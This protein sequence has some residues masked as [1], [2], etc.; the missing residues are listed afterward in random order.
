MGL[1]LAV[2]LMLPAGCGGGSDPADSPAAP[3]TTPAPPADPVPAGPAGDPDPSNDLGPIELPEV[4]AA[5][6]EPLTGELADHFRLIR[7]GHPDWARVR[8]R[9]YLNVNPG[10]GRA[11]FLFGLTYHREKRYELAR[12]SFDEAIRLAPDY[13][14]THYFLGW[15][16]YY[17]GEPEAARDAFLR[18]LDYQPREGDSHFAL[19]L[20]AL[21]ADELKEAERRFRTAIMLSAETEGRTKELSK[22][23][24][25]LSDVLVRTDRLEEARREL[26]LAVELHPEY[27]E[28][29]YKLYRVCT[30]LG[31]EAAALEAKKT[32]E[33]IRERTQPGTSFPE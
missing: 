17:L 1:L 5:P 27:D 30:R 18:H 11:H 25:R 33:Q 28:A 7:E 22:S 29:H 3:P 13:Y 14:A 6:A 16:Q 2:A 4:A 10:D 20:I 31:D 24:A 26:E 19:G 9:K 15:A 23:R 12:E 21:D 8:L 32:Y